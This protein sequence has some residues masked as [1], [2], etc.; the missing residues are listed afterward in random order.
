MYF[1]K[2]TTTTGSIALMRISRKVEDNLKTS[3]NHG[4]NYGPMS[5]AVVPNT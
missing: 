5:R 4:Q 2:K 3:S 1:L